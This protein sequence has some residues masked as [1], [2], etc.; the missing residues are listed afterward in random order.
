LI[1]P[2][3]HLTIEIPAGNVGLLFDSS[4]VTT[5]KHIRVDHPE[6]DYYQSQRKK[7]AHRKT[8]EQAYRSWQR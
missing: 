4:A 5:V 8:L 2:N 1:D 7:G 6:G 3:L